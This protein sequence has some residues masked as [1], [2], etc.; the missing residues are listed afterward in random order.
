MI[1]ESR[2]WG[3]WESKSWYYIS[4]TTPETGARA[5]HGPYYLT[6]R[7][8]VDWMLDVQE[9]R[10]GAYLVEQFRWNGVAWERV[11]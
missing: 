1:A 9:A 5:Y 10:W 8:R 4:E 6:E 11:L 2:L 7:G 3:W